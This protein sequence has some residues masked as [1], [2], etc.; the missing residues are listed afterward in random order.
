MD[1]REI[2]YGETRLSDAYIS[3][4]IPQSVVDFY[5]LKVTDPDYFDM[6]IRKLGID[7]AANFSLPELFAT[8][9][10]LLEHTYSKISNVVTPWIVELAKKE[11]NLEGMLGPTKSKLPII[12][13]FSGDHKNIFYESSQ[14]MAFGILLVLRSSRE[15]TLRVVAPPAVYGDIAAN[16][17]GSVNDNDVRRYAA[18]VIFNVRGIYGPVSSKIIFNTLDVIQGIIT[19]AS[20]LGEDPHNYISDITDNGVHMNF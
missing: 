14:D 5:G 20:W 13:K 11:A 3:F 2:Q 12:I 15:F 19:A 6:E 4:T 7:G 16:Y 18:N 9:R 8:V 10:S 1:F 17:F